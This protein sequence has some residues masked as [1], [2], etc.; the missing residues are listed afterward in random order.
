MK[1]RRYIILLFCF[2]VTG[3]LYPQNSHV[4]AELVLKDLF[5]RRSYNKILLYLDKLSSTYKDKGQLKIY[6]GDAYI[7]LDSLDKAEL[8]FRQ[9]L[10]YHKR[11]AFF[12][13]GETYFLKNNLTKAKLYFTKFLRIKNNDLVTLKYLGQIAIARQDVQKIEYYYREVYSQDSS[14]VDALLNLGVISMNK[15]KFEDAEYFL[16][17][18]IIYDPQNLLVNLNLG[19]LFASNGDYITAEKYLKRA[20]R[21]SPKDDRTIYTLGIIYLFEKKWRKAETLLSKALYLNPQSTD[22]RAA[23]VILYE[24][25]NEILK[26][27]KVLKDLTAQQPRYHN[28]NLLKANLFYLKHKYK[29][30]I[31]YVMREIENTPLRSDLYLFLG[32]LYELTDNGGK[33]NEAYDY[34]E[35]V[36]TAN[37][38]T[39]FEPDLLSQIA[40]NINLKTTGN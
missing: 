35:E 32:R 34:A 16:R 21:I 11:T 40:I 27:S 15:G 7:G 28:L 6:Y 38:K 8:F 30:A 18:A 31:K 25:N 24:A 1:F 19:I 33:A 29:T 23:L 36:K 9:A 14:D 17:K 12:N 37:R 13:L 22:A 5:N 2:V 10:L 3:M 26:A 4:R 20:L 39:A